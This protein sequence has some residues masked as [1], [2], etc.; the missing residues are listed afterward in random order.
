MIEVN[1][2]SFVTLKFP[3][4]VDNFTVTDCNGD[5]YFFK[6]LNESTDVYSFN[7]PLEN[8]YNVSPEPEC[9]WL[10]PLK[11][12]VRKMWLKFPDR[13]PKHELQIVYNPSLNTLACCYQ[14]DCVIEVS[15]QYYKLP[16]YARVFILYHEIGHLYYDS[17]FDA[18]KFA[19]YHYMNDGFNPSSALYAKTK[20]LGNTDEESDRIGD[21]YSNILKYQK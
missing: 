7:L 14:D 6:H 16:F 21:S 3:N 20:Y 2:P 18:D 19:D 11:K 15:D 1:T 9:Y 17:E 12:M 4:K 5:V 13:I 10:E 8:W